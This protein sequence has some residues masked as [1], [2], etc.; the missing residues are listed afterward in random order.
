MVRLAESANAVS[1]VIEEESSDV[2]EVHDVAFG[3]G[4][5]FSGEAPDAL[6]EREVEPLDMVC[7]SFL[8]GAGSVL[9]VGHNLLIRAPEVGE[10]EAGFVSGRNLFPKRPTTEHRARAVVP[11]HDLPGAT[12]QR[13]PE[14]DRVLFA[15]H[16]APQLVQLQ[17]IALLGRQERLL[18]FGYG[19]RAT[20]QVTVFF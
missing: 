13:D 9:F 16:I 2:D 3:E 5:S 17:H 20:P 7:L 6:P 10:D 8:F 11:G 14:P 15:A 18:H 4:E 12:A 19:R 1:V